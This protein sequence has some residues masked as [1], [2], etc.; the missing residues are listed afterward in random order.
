M[1]KRIIFSIHRVLGSVLSILFLV[2]FL[3]GFVMLYRSFPR[4]SIED[5][6]RVA[7]ALSVDI[8]PIDSVLQHIPTE[9]N[10]LKLDI[11]RYYGQ[12]IYRITTTDSA[13]QLTSD[14]K[15]SSLTPTYEQVEDY[16]KLWC[17]AGIAK[18]ET[19]YDI[20]QWIPF[21]RLRADLPIYKFHFNDEDKHQLYVSSRTG[22]A[23]QLTDK[24]SRFWAWLGAI[25]HWVYFTPIRED[26]QFWSTLVIWLSGIGS[27]MCLAGLVAG[28]WMFCKRYKTK[29]KFQSPYK[30]FAY[31]WHHIL[32]FVFGFFTFTFVFSG[33]MSLAKVP[34]WVAKVHNPDLMRGL[35]RQVLP[36]S[37][38]DYVLD[39][40]T[41]L[42]AYPNQVKSIEWS[43][44]DETPTYKVRVGTELLMFDA[45]T[46]EI[47]P[48]AVTENDIRKRFTK[49]HANDDFTISVMTEY[50]NYYLSKK[51]DLELPV[52]KVTVNDADNSAYYVSPTTGDTRYFNSKSR[53]QKW[54]Y[55]GFHSFNIKFLVDRPVLWH[56]VMWTTMLGGTFVSAT[57]VWLGYKWIR[58]KIR[59]LRKRI[60]GSNVKK[61]Q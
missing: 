14:F 13:Y 1:V 17:N 36:V 32:G 47:K 50:D 19:L 52:Y 11:R 10:I 38:K 15:A 54:M 31:K 30:K 39:Y 18:V 4:V 58:R 51:H 53:M 55:Q 34:D 16:A 3:S 22:E 28:I 8:P 61:Q 6:N 45:S 26:S 35:H 43:S 37:P 23:L 42:T 44:F 5:R 40:R 21:N 2:W 29:K 25:P 9:S 56:V 33:M 48:L 7:Q 12:Q 20:D 46:N 49:L 59:W 60:A 27:I 41:V 57:G 24:D